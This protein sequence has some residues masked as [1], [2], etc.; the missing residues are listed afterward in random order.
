MNT[1]L[2]RLRQ[3]ALSRDLVA[4]FGLT[5]RSLIQPYFIAPEGADSQPI[6]G[7]TRVHLWSTQDLARQMERDVE[8]GVRYFLLFGSSVPSARVQLGADFAWNELPIVAALIQLRRIFGEAIWLGAD[9]CLCPYSPHGHCGIFEGK[10]L[11][12]GL[13]LELLSRQAEAL[14]RAGVDAVAPSDMM[15]GRVGAI[16]RHLDATGFKRTAI[17]SYSVKYHS[18][19]YGP[20]RDAFQSSPSLHEVPDR[21][22]YQMDYRSASESLIEVE[23][24]QA[25]GA[26]LILVKPALA[27]LDILALVAKQSKIPVL[28]YNVSGEYE[29]V[30]RL[31]AAG[32]CSVRELASENLVAMRRAGARAIVTYFASQAAEEGWFLA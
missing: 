21:R 28:A 17:L 11:N 25:E 9:V 31:A 16:R 18:H 8:K 2:T 4:E 26:D 19:Y 1:Q 12:H 30:H 15:E 29:M 7:F 10:H 24:D 22:G 14:A 23:H 27:Y 32:F 20:F 13:T 5:L 6:S 3:N